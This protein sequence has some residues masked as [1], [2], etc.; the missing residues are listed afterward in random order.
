[1]NKNEQKSL[2]EV[3]TS[4]RKIEERAKSI[5]ITHNY[6]SAHFPGLLLMVN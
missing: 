4:K 1:M 6:M 3:P 2:S 5:P